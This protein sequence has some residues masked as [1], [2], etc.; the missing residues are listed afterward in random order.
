MND[1]S[2]SRLNTVMILWSNE[3]MTM[4]FNQN[5]IYLLMSGS[6]HLDRALDVEIGVECQIFVIVIFFD[7]CRVLQ[8]G[9]HSRY[10]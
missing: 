6:C 1:V 10:Y 8:F 7:C 4:S 5:I 3:S 2:V 9:A